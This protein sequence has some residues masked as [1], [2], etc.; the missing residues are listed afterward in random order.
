MKCC[1]SESSST[2]D[3]RAKNSDIKIRLNMAKIGLFIFFIL[4]IFRLLL[5]LTGFS[6][7]SFKSLKIKLLVYLK[8]N[9]F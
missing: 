6:N 1:T 2:N 7:N 9:T 4:H 5:F 3:I 8:F